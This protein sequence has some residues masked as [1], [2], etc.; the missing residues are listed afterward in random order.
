MLAAPIHQSLVRPSPVLMAS[1][2]ASPLATRKAAEPRASG[3]HTR[4]SATSAL[5]FM[6]TALPVLQLNHSV[7]A[8]CTAQASQAMFR[9]AHTQK[10]RLVPCW[11]RPSTASRYCR[12]AA[13]V[14]NTEPVKNVNDVAS[15]P[16]A[17]E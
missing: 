10:R 13:D 4:W 11:P 12:K 15:R 8:N 6:R 1:I 9:G 7:P 3:R 16:T 17:S 14:K 5:R 2:H